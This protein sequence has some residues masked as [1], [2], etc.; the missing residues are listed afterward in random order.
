ME[1]IRLVRKLYKGVSGLAIL[2]ALIDYNLASRGWL[3]AP[4]IF[5]LNPLRNTF[6]FL[7][8]QINHFLAN[9]ITFALIVSLVF[10]I[11]AFSRNKPHI[12]VWA[13]LIAFIE[14]SLMGIVGWTIAF[15]R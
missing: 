5:E 14:C 8:T 10:L 9:S 13:L 12:L 2:L 3:H 4:A 6:I 7:F 11:Y 1:K 15:Y